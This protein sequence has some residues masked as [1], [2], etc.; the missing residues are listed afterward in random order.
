MRLRQG[1]TLTLLCLSAA[2]SFAWYAAWSAKGGHDL[3]L[4]QSQVFELH[5]RLLYA[6]KENKER[7]HELKNVLKAIRQVI[8]ERNSTSTNIPPSTDF[9]KWKMLHFRNRLPIHLTNIHYYLP[10]LQEHEDGIQ[11]NVVIGQGRTGV[12]LVIG[13]PTVRR[14]KENYLM[15]TLNSLFYDVSEEQKENLVVVIFVAEV[16]S[17]YV[18]GIAERIRTSFTNEIVSGTLEVISPPSS[19]YPELSNLKETLGDSA[20]RVK[21][22]SK[23][24]LD[25]TFLMLYAQPKGTFYLQLEDDIIAKPSYTEDIKNFVTKQESKDWMILE[26]SQL[27]F[28][29]KLFKTRDIPLIVEF[30]LMFYQDKPIDWLLDHLLWVKVCHPEKNANHCDK[31]KAFLRIRYKPSLFQHVGLHSSLAGKIQQLK[32][33]DFEKNSLFIAHA[34]PPAEVSTSLKVYQDF[35][36]EK[37]YKGVECFWAIAPMA[38]DYILF[39]FWQPLKIAS[40]LFKS[41]NM[42]HPGDQ[43]F[44]TSVEILLHDVS[45]STPTILKNITEDGYLQIGAFVKGVATGNINPVFGRIEAVRLSIHSSSPMWVLLNEIFIKRL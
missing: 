21:W 36:L 1:A 26:F 8:D 30:F 19:Y 20:D 29:G 17:E 14:E 42:A 16:D 5:Q 10:H 22:R 24:I 33:K 3:N 6:E 9:A 31:Q 4:F 35:T 27:G 12:S 7:S 45:I 43:L 39:R 2:L 25:Y 40:Y 38:G 34:N 13:I 32:D 23:Q 37:A 44:N 18:N 41:G 28:I 15:N 11:P